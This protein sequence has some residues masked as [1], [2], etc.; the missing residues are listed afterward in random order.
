MGR[1]LHQPPEME[2]A[3]EEASRTYDRAIELGQTE[4]QAIAAAKRVLERRLGPKY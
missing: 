3:W 1:V 2:Q 4:E